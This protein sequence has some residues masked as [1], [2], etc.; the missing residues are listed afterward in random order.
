[1]LFT[2]YNNLAFICQCG[3]KKIIIASFFQF[4]ALAEF[5]N[6]RRKVTDGQVCF[7]HTLQKGL[8]FFFTKATH[9]LHLKL[10]A[11][12]IFDK[13]RRNI[14]M[15]AWR[16]LLHGIALG[17]RTIS[18]SFHDRSIRLVKISFDLMSQ[19]TIRGTFLLLRESIFLIDAITIQRP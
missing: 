14:Q 12:E 17:K 2:F 18:A 3:S 16:K 9:S 11:R 8:Q 19:R 4:Q 10:P 13:M 1:M 15:A 5:G 6:G 7:L